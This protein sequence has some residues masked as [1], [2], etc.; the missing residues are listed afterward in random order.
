MFTFHKPKVIADWLREPK[1]LRNNLKEIPK[2]DYTNLWD[3]QKEAV[4]N[5]ENSMARNK[6]RALIQMTTG[7]GKTFTA[8]TALYILIKYTK[9]NRVLFLVDRGNLRIQAN[10]EFQNYET[11]DGGRKFTELYNRVMRN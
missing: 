1:I 7:S 4:I 8:V 10:K 5:L 9:V 3:C 11:V 2:L 6:P